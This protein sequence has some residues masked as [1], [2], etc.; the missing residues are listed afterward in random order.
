MERLS[1]VSK[2]SDRSG[3]A[4]PGNQMRRIGREGAYF[5]IVEGKSEVAGLICATTSYRGPVTIPRHVHEYPSLFL[6]LRG[7]F[8]SKRPEDDR[9]IRAGEAACYAPLEPHSV[10]VSRGRAVG[11]NVEVTPESALWEVFANGDAGPALT[12]GNGMR[13][14]PALLGELNTELLTAD[15]LTGEAVEAICVLLATSVQRDRKRRTRTSAPPPWL[16]AVAEMLRVPS[17]RMPRTHELA[18]LAGVPVPELVREFRQHMG[19]TPA[20]Y[21][22]GVKVK[23]GARLLLET[24]LPVGDV[25]LRA[26]FYDQSHFCRVFRRATGETPSSF[27]SKRSGQ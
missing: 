20:A 4:T 24:S 17:A 22:R 8:I 9:P 21:A 2:V 5:G 3:T 13:S 6:S 26:A 23:T 7:D 10:T 14:F 1:A 11:F 15:E 12:R 27:R 16:D 19:C 18:A 25:A